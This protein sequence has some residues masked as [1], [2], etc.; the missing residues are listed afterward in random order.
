VSAAAATHFAVSAPASATAGVAV[1]FTVTAR[2]PFNNTDTGYPGVVHFTSTDGAATLPG[3]SMLTGGVGT[4]SATLKTAGSQTL[5]ATDTAVS[6]VTGTS[7]PITVSPAAATH[8]AVSAP[9][10]ATPGV[11]FTFTVTARDPFDNTAPGYTGT[12]HFTSTDAGATLPANS[13]LMNGVGTFSAT[14]KTLPATLTATDTANA[15]ITGTSNPITFSG[16]TESPPA[17]FDYAL[18]NSGPITVTQGSGGSTTIAATLLSGTTQTVSLAA[19]G[20]PAGA[21]AGFTLSSCSP[22]C[23]SLLTISTTA[24]TPT[25]TFPITVTGTPLGRTT[26]F[27][28]VVSGSKDV[29]PILK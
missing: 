8:F 7:T 18:G 17:A 12:V 20:L 13:T 6:S 3:N 1:S 14:L 22:T 10:S 19:S 26:S 29:P 16:K 23:T 11:A 15:A 24:A 21:T 27:N 4:F 9:A 28:L 5:T 25:G 2:D